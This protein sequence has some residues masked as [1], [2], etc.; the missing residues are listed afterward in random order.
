VLALRTRSM[1]YG[2]IVHGG[3]ALFMDVVSKTGPLH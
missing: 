2:T 3:V 1:W